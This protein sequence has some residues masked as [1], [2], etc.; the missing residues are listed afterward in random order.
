MRSLFLI[1]LIS[2]IPSGIWGVDLLPTTV[3]TT[4]AESPAVT[5]AASVD[6]GD[7]AADSTIYIR[8]RLFSSELDRKVSS[9][10]NFD[11]SSITAAD[12]DSPDF[13]V[14]FTADFDFRLNPSNSAPA[15]VGRVTNGAWDGTTIL[16]LHSWGISDSADRATLIPDI[17]SA[18]A[19]APVSV[20]V[21]DI[22][23]GWVDGTV[24]NFGL[25]VFV[26]TQMSNAA[27]FSNPRLVVTSEPDGDGSNTEQLENGPVFPFIDSDN[28]GY[29]DEA[30]VA[31]GTSPTDGT[32]IPDNR[33]SAAR[34]NVV[35]IYADDLGFGDISCLWRLVRHYQQCA[36]SSY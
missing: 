28:D 4:N 15:T 11:V 13:A 23:S 33:N 31:F 3:F 25:A 20:D 26:G 14:S 12:L 32:E 9:F 17:S 10:L 1:S 29:R 5:G 34:P 19:P 24:D 8:E 2:I 6:S 18:A 30:E 7:P 22:V 21:T 16:P 35:I 36:H 27:G